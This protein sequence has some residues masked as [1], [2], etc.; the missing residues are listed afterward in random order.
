LKL[1]FVYNANSG[2]LNTLWDT[3]HKIFSPKNYS[4]N[5]CAITFD[6]FSEK[7]IWKDFRENFNTEMVFLHRDEFQ[8]QYKSKWLQKFKFPVIL[9]TKNEGLEVFISSE[10]LSELKSPDSLIALITHRLNWY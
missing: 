5:L 10:E 2:K 9:V 8:K 6:I 1:I 4:C 3:A 7:K